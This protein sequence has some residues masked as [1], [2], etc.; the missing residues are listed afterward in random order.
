MISLTEIY[1]KLIKHKWAKVEP[2]RKFRHHK[3]T[4][5]DAEK[6]YDDREGKIMFMDR[7]G[8]TLH[9][10]PECVLP[11]TKLNTQIPKY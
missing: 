5:C 10:T 8:H 4:R 1:H 11:N 9:H 3:C 6:W 7:F 2:S